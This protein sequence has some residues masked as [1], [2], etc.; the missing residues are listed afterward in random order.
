MN[1]AIKKEILDL[2]EKQEFYW[3]TEI[4]EVLWKNRVVIQR[5]LKKLIEV[6]I[7]EKINNWPKTKYKKIFS[8]WEKK[9]FEDKKKKL[10]DKK[11]FNPDFRLDFKMEKILEENFW[12]FSP[13]W[14]ILKWLSWL[15]EWC[16]ARNLDFEEKIKTFINTFNYIEDLQDNCWL[17]DAKENFWMHFEKVYLDEIFYADQ[18]KWM[19]FWRWKLAEMTFYAKQ[20]QDKKLIFDSINQMILKLKCVILKW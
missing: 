16:F 19:E 4:A 15:Q 11:F 20:S 10:D 3:V 1:F 6:W 5:Y 7:L 12:K 8:K 9:I 13:E 14:R 17:L 2:F 18:Y